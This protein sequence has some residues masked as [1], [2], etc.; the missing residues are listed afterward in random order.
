[1]SLSSS[2]TSATPSRGHPPVPLPTS[3]HASR[4]TFPPSPD[5]FPCTSSHASRVTWPPSPDLLPCSHPF[6]APHRGSRITPEGRVAPI[7]CPPARARRRPYRVI[8]SEP[9]ASR[10]I[11][12]PCF[13]GPTACC[14]EARPSRLWRDVICPCL[15]HPRALAMRSAYHPSSLPRIHPRNHD[16]QPLFA[17]VQYIIPQQRAVS[18]ENKYFSILFTTLRRW[19]P[20]NLKWLQRNGIAH[21]LR[22]RQRGARRPPEAS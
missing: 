19:C 4:V 11:W 6:R 9:K 21:Q 8:P 13:P 18:S 22:A 15:P 3:S 2:P 17:N 12:P 14:E 10:G 7:G 20:G 16:N 1:M 5:L